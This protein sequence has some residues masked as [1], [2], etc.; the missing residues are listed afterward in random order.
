MLEIAF[1]KCDRKVRKTCK[2]DADITEWMK[3]RSIFIV[4]NRQLFEPAKFGDKRFRK[5]AQVIEIPLDIES[6]LMSYY[7]VQIQSLSSTESFWPGPN[8][9]ET[10]WNLVFKKNMK[11]YWNPKQWNGVLIDV[12]PDVLK[13]T[14]TVY[15]IVNWMSEV[16]GFI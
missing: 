3:E 15:S 16:G 8:S 5:S 7:T 4:V 2:S 10:Y 11:Y 14:R 9:E 1:E 6:R 12:D 13:T